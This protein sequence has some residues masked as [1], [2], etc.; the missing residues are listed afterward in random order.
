MGGGGRK[1]KNGIKTKQ[2]CL[3]CIG[4]LSIVETSPPELIL[5][6]KIWG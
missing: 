1:P 4:V 3:P 6:V 2:H 5:G